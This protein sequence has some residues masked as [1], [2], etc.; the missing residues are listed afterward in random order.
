MTLHVF[1][2]T[3]RTTHLDEGAVGDG[4]G[5]EG[6][7]VRDGQPQGD[8]RR[9]SGAGRGARGGEEGVGEAGGVGGRR[10]HLCGREGVAMTRPPTL[11]R[12]VSAAQNVFLGVQCSLKLLLDPGSPGCGQV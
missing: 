5:G 10:L 11:K 2:C 9:A 4:D 3:W 7:W 1:P 12:P 6:V 8:E